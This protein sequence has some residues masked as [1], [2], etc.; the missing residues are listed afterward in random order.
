MRAFAYHS[1]KSLAEAVAVLEREGPGGRVIAG[2]TD[3]LVQAKERGAVPAYVVSL[4]DVAELATLAYDDTDGLTIGARVALADVAAH[5]DVRRHYAAL[6]TGA[7][8]VGSLQIQNRGTIGGNV[9]NASP[10]AD[11]APPLLVAGAV[12]RIHGPGGKPRELPMADFFI[13]PGRTTLI[14]G[15]VLVAIH[16][17]AQP[18]RTG[19]AYERHTPRQEMDIAIAGVAAQVTL[20]GNGAIAALGI[21]LGAVGPTPFRATGAEARGIGHLPDDATISDVARIAAGEARPISDQRGS[22]DYRR[23][24]VEVLTRRTVHAAVAQARVA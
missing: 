7:S 18:R 6:A 10:S 14:A 16:L 19:S 1:P 15:E 23:R 17:P 9:C 20:D 11:T 13:G 24:L 12:A 3:L 21:A 2:G 8:L 4:K 5:P 22:A